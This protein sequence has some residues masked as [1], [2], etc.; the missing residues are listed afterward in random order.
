M[1]YKCGNYKREIIANDY[2]LDK[3]NQRIE[4]TM[5]N[6]LKNWQARNYLSAVSKNLKCGA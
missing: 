4:K 5:L 2:K 6:S 1:Q 3:L